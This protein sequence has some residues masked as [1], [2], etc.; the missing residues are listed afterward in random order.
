M[1]GLMEGSIGKYDSRSKAYAAIR[2]WNL[3]RLVMIPAKVT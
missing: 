1:E 3:L 2:V